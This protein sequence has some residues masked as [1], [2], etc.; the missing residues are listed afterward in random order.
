LQE[1]KQRLI[2]EEWIVKTYVPKLGEVQK[3]CYVIDAEGKVLGRVAAEAAKLLRGKHKPQYTPYLDCGDQVIII[4][5]AKAAVTGRKREQK[6]YYRH[7]GHPGGLSEMNYD[8]LMDKHPTRAMYLAVKGMLPHNRLGR[9]LARHM[10]VYPDA[11]HPHE[12]QQPEI[13]EFK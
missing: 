6:M 5:A 11:T 10:R 9:K 8:T 4:N 1:L 13:Y 3:K 7:S 12:A 2:P